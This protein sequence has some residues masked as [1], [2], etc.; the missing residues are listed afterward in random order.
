MEN[1]VY[2]EIICG[3]TA[4]VKEMNMPFGHYYTGY[5]EILSTD[6]LSWKKSFR[7]GERNIF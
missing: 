1:I 7:D 5:I 2:N 6:P 3:R 4:V